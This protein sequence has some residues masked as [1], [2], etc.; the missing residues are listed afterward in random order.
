MM[1]LPI[2]SVSISQH[3]KSS[4][5]S[6]HLN[7][8]LYPKTEQNE[9]T[10]SLAS[11]N[12]EENV[13][14]I[15][16]AKQQDVRILVRWDWIGEIDCRGVSDGIKKGRREKVSRCDHGGSGLSV[17]FQ[18]KRNEEKRSE[19]KLISLFSN[20]VS[21]SPLLTQLPERHRLTNSALTRH[22]GGVNTRGGM[23]Q[24]RIE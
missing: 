17:V 1:R 7:Q 23:M 6:A 12:R 10:V 22:Y 8:K 19:P 14:N 3:V 18:E 4:S 16:T 11:V 13:P 24:K 5:R 2:I 15:A 21:T 20:Y 9:H